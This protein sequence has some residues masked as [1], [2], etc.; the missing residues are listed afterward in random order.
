MK[1]ILLFICI[2]MLNLSFTMAEE[3]DLR[4]Q[5]SNLWSLEYLNRYVDESFSNIAKVHYKEMEK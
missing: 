3:K 2:L 4:Y 1:K 5:E